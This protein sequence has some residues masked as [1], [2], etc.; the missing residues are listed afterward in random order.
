[1]SRAV[2]VTARSGNPNTLAFGPQGDGLLG[3]SRMIFTQPLS[4]IR[5]FVEQLDQGIRE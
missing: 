2:G 5:E 3:R 4:F 1:M